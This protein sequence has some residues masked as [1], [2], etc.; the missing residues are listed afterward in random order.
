MPSQF[1]DLCSRQDNWS[2]ALTIDKVV[3]CAIKADVPTIAYV[4]HDILSGPSLRASAVADSEP[5]QPHG[6]RTHIHA[7]RK[8]IIC[9]HIAEPLL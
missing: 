9:I 7:W 2:A 4:T 3:F 1:I 8:L 5:G 6:A